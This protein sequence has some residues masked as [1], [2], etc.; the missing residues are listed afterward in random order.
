MYELTCLD[1]DDNTLK[2]IKQ[3]LDAFKNSLPPDNHIIGPSNTMRTKAL[4]GSLGSLVKYI[5]GMEVYKNPDAFLIIGDSLM[6]GVWAA[7]SLLL[8]DKRPMS[9][10]SNNRFM[11]SGIYA[12]YY[13]GKHP[14]YAKLSGTDHPIYIG[15]ADPSDSSAKSPREQGKN[16]HNRLREHAR[17]ILNARFVLDKN[18]KYKKFTKSLMED[19][20]DLKYPPVYIRISDFEYRYLSLSSGSQLIIEDSLIKLYKPIWNKEQ[21]IL[22]GFGKHGD[23]HE[24]RSNN[25]SEWDI[26]HPGRR[27]AAESKTKK[28]TQIIRRDLVKY[29]IDYKVLG[30][31]DIMTEIKKLM[32]PV[33]Y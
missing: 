10:L 30:L 2:I 22:K 21:G 5:R 14:I 29:L 20:C 16:L 3:N 11:G 28:S 6:Y 24:T 8:M 7:I 26:L 4:D 31:D 9:Q 12:I 17:T 1:M 27:W 25:K 13:K 32:R 19:Y 18:F 15:K 33:F 23:N